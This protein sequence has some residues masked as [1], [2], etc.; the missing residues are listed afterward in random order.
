MGQ[1]PV[2][3]KEGNGK[4]RFRRVLFLG[5]ALF[6]FILLGFMAFAGIEA[7]SYYS[8]SK[9]TSDS[10]SFEVLASMFQDETLVCYFRN[11]GTKPKNCTIGVYSVGGASLG[12]HPNGPNPQFVSFKGNETKEIRFN[13][14]KENYEP[15]TAVK[16]PYCGIIIAI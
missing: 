11:K 5:S 9:E 2:E 7:L 6:F 12:R 8:K 15:H 14:D 16:G 10:N 3:T 1:S 13:F 4:G